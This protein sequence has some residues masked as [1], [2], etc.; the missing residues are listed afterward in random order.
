MSETLRLAT[1]NLES[2]DDSGKREA[3]F[4]A[5]LPGLRAKLSALK[6]DV[7]CLQEVNAQKS[8]S[9]GRRRF[10]ALDRL[11]EGTPYAG[12]GRVETVDPASGGPSDVHNLVIL[13]RF[14]IRESRRVLHELAPPLR[15]PAVIGGVRASGFVRWD[16]PL[17]YAC[18]ELGGGRR[19]HV[20]NVHLRAPRAAAVAGR[21]RTGRKWGDLR[22]WAVGLFAASLKRAGQALEARLLIESLFDAEADAWLAVCG[23]FNA[24]ENELPLRLVEG[25]A[26][27]VGNPELAGRLLTAVEDV[28][29]EASRYSVLHHGRRLMLDHIL[30]SASLAR[31]LSDV[32][33]DNR[34]LADEAAAPGP[35]AAGSFHAP[36]AAAF[37][38][39]APP[40]AAARRKA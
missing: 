27:D 13:S 40:R 15:W 7:L 20:V 25:D 37:S 21:K 8:A 30:V 12:F 3:E 31:L 11:L 33:I 4:R 39:P 16:R 14:P 28:A 34:G 36:L 26:D 32:R 2:L 17:L 23:D 1:F 18:L 24:D 35:G 9:A 6:A 5:R 38:L 19:L 22:G 10:R 29:A